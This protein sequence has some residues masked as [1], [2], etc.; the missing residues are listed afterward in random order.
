MHVFWSKGYTGASL[1]DLTAAMR[2]NKSSLYNSFKDKHTLFTESLKAYIKLVEKDYTSALN[3]GYSA[4]E[5]IDSIIDKIVEISTDRENS[6]FGIKTAFELASYDKEVN[7]MLKAGQDKT[8]GLIRSLLSEAQESGQIKSG[9]DLETMSHFIFNSF[10]G[11]RQSYIIYGNRK[12]IN[13]MAGE[14][15]AYLRY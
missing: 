12:L 13:L 9:R 6:C 11:I 4:I 15:K 2:I 5:K 3:P 7:I 14:L 1:A 10:A 8:I